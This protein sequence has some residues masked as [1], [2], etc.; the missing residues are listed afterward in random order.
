MALQKF[1]AVVGGYIKQ[2]SPVQ[3]S[4]G[5]ADAGSIP[6]LDS[7]GKLDASM[8]PASASSTSVV[9]AT[10]SEAISAGA[11]VN[12]YNNAGTVTVQNADNSTT[13][14]E[15]NGFVTSAF[16]GSGVSGTV[17]LSGEITGLTSITPGQDYW[18]GTVG[19]TTTTPPTAAGTLTQQVGYGLTST[20]IMFRPHQ[21]IQN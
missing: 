20:S 1:L 9:T 18:L 15:A 12:V 4:T 10:S 11:L 7:S 14:K 2:I 3:A 17:I 6:A 13:G 5:A 16:S 21:P 8:I 19:A